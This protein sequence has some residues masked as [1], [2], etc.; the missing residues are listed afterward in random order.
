MGRNG[1]WRVCYQSALYV[2]NKFL[3]LPGLIG[4]N[5]PNGSCV[6]S[7]HLKGS[8][9]QAVTPI[10]RFVR[11]VLEPIEEGKE[12]ILRFVATRKGKQGIMARLSKNVSRNDHCDLRKSII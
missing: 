4:Y 9:V 6:R 8:T 3:L 11:S 2:V 5:L 7:V 12:I 10:S 1:T